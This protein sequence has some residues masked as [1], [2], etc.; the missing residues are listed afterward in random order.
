MH[1]QDGIGSASLILNRFC[2]FYGMHVCVRE[3]KFV[4]RK[5]WRAFLSFNICFKIRPFALLPTIYEEV[6]ETM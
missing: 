5:I 3:E 6:M 4:F 1:S 2:S